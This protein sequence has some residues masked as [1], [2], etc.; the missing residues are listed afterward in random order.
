MDTIT[1]FLRRLWP[2]GE[3]G[4][5]PTLMVSGQVVGALIIC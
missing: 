1:S 3:G 5:P 4:G 2:F